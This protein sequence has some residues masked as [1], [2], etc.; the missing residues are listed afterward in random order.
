[1]GALTRT[2]TPHRDSGP[3]DERKKR[4]VLLS[5]EFKRRLNQKHAVGYIYIISKQQNDYPKIEVTS[6]ERRGTTG[7]QIG[8]WGT[9][10][11]RAQNVLFLDLHDLG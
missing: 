10:S 5:T 9:V 6:S 1:M 8:A 7:M 3:R 2:K 11:R 4:T